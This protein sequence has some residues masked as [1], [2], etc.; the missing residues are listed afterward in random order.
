MS[1]M[2]SDTH[3]CVKATGEKKISPAE[4]G[5]VEQKRNCLTCGRPFASEWVGER[6]CKRCKGSATWR[7][8]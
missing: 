2:V 3:Q 8:G 1:G 5:V 7:Q 6:V 4:V